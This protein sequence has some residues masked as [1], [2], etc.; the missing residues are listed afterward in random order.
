[1]LRHRKELRVIY[2]AKFQTGSKSK[3]ALVRASHAVRCGR[4][5]N[6]LVTELEHL[7]GKGQ[8]PLAYYFGSKTRMEEP[9]K[10]VDI[11]HNDTGADMNAVATLQQEHPHCHIVRYAILRC[12]ISGT[13]YPIPCEV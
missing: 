9:P 4:V 3:H 12:T 10:V 5:S 11:R 2:E 1:M 6:W 8:N 13:M 7:K